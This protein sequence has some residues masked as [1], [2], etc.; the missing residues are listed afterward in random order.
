MM[1]KVVLPLAPFFSKQPRPLVHSQQAAVV[2]NL[3]AL[4][5]ACHQQVKAGK[6]SRRG[7]GKTLS[8]GLLILMKSG[9]G[10]MLQRRHAIKDDQEIFF[11]D[12]VY[13]LNQPQRFYSSPPLGQVNRRQ[14]LNINKS[15]HNSF[16]ISVEQTRYI[17]TSSMARTTTETGGRRW[18][19]I[20]A[21]FGNSFKL[22]VTL[23]HQSAFNSQTSP[24]LMRLLVELHGDVC[25]LYN[26]ILFV[27]FFFAF[28]LNTNNVSFTATTKPLHN[29]EQENG[30]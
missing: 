28:S 11:G 29:T 13:C 5:T 21:P 23:F 16:S 19:M 15:H 27:C 18:R 2:L 25:T 26:Y 24:C 9:F 20:K 8:S 1:K 10:E 22:L 7:R 17:G 6:H 3:A 14:H 30:R 4:S 12:W